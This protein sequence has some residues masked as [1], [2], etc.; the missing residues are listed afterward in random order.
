MNLYLREIPKSSRLR[1]EIRNNLSH[2]LC[3]CFCFLNVQIWPINDS[4]ASWGVP[5]PNCPSGHLLMYLFICAHGPFTSARPRV[6]AAR[7]LIS[8]AAPPPISPQMSRS[9]PRIISKPMKVRADHWRK[10]KFKKNLFA[11]QMLWFQFN[12]KFHF[13]NQNNSTI[14]HFFSPNLSESVR[15]WWVLVLNYH[16]S[17]S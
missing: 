11:V 9:V 10:R 1:R 8:I 7:P 16:P 2:N 15:S 5:W 13:P 3:I 12:L 4:F 17:V 14:T 6:H